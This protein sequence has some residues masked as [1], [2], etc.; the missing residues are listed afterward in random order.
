MGHGPFYFYIQQHDTGR[1]YDDIRQRYM[2]PVTNDMN[3]FLAAIF[4]TESI[5]TEATGLEL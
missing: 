4:D 2:Y 5:V 3:T 1:F